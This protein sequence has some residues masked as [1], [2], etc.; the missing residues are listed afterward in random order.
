MLLF[1]IYR[2]TSEP[3]KCFNIDA[4]EEEP[5]NVANATEDEGPRKTEGE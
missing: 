2:K 4:E 3:I 5:G 1:I